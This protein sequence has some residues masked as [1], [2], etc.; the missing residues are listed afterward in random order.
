M[1]FQVRKMRLGDIES[2]KEIEKETAL[3]SWSVEDLRAELSRD[4]SIQVTCETEYKVVGF[5]IM[6]LIITTEEAE[7]LNIAVRRELEGRGIGTAMLEKLFS[8][9]R[10]RNFKS[11]WL[12]VRESNARALNFYRRLGFQIAG[13]RKNFYRN[14]PEDA[15]LMKLDLETALASEKNLV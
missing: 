1:N 14:P 10:R 15:L 11:V 9:L 5:V 8:E 13:R 7:I 2:V 12:E 3:E 6:R 4:D